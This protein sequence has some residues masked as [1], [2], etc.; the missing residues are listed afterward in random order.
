MD[1]KL[2]RR[3]NCGQHHG[4]RCD[5]GGFPN[6]EIF[7]TGYPGNPAGALNHVYILNNEL[8]GLNGVNSQDEWGIGGWDM[9]KIFLMSCT[10]K[11]GL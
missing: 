10:R 11:S 2:K 5:I 1:P 3:S 9:V 7:I 8:H 6:D 4:A